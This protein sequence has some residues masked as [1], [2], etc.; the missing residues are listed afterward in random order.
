VLA[1]WAARLPLA[2]VTN[3]VS[4]LQRDK[5]A[6]TGIEGYFSVVVASEEIGVGK[7]DHAMFH[8]ALSAL[9]ASADEV[10]MVGNDVD[11]DVAGAHNVHIRPIHVDRRRRSTTTDVIADLTQLEDLL[12]V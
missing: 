9:G 11:R 12:D 10:V 6:A 3:G 5:L 4:R 7:P 8:A 1:H 2:L